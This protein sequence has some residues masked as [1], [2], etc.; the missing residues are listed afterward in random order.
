MGWCQQLYG[1]PN[2]SQWLGRQPPQKRESLCCS[3]HFSNTNFARMG[4]QGG[5]LTNYQIRFF[6]STTILF[7]CICLVP[8]SFENLHLVCWP[9]LSVANGMG[10]TCVSD[11]ISENFCVFD[12]NLIFCCRVPKSP[13]NFMWKFRGVH[14][15]VCMRT[16]SMLRRAGRWLHSSSPC[17][18]SPFDISS[19]LNNTADMCLLPAVN[20]IMLS[21]NTS[22]PPTLTC[23]SWCTAVP[24]PSYPGCLC[25]R[26]H[27]SPSFFESRV[28]IENW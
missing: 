28:F 23:S 20:M 25:R 19:Q 6:D 5:F 12:P 2:L 10:T 11:L 27:T 4:S 17:P 14:Q 1:Y 13:Q 7:L 21:L 8:E 22:R 24:A 15:E 9:L 16:D 3:V 26:P 18:S